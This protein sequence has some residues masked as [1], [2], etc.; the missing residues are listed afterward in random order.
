MKSDRRTVRTTVHT[1]RAYEYDEVR[2][3]EKA[4]K[5]WA[6][7]QFRDENAHSYCTGVTS[8]FNE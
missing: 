7:S 5:T 8:Y 2:R 4:R 6:G 3:Q 1:L